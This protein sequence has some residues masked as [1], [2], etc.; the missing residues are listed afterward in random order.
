MIGRN[1]FR[2][3]AV[4]MLLCGAA[5]VSAQPYVKFV[6][7]FE[8]SEGY[9]AGDEVLWQPPSWSGSTTGILCDANAQG[10]CLAS[11]VDPFNNPWDNSQVVSDVSATDAQSYNIYFRWLDPAN[12]NG[13]AAARVV[14]VG[15][16]NLPSPSVQLNGKIRFKMAV[17]GWVWD[18][19]GQF[20]TQVT[21]GSSILM[22]LALRETG[23]DVAQ[24]ETDTGGG[25]L[26]FVYLPTIDVSPTV[27]TNGIADWPPGGKRYAATP[28]WPPLSNEWYNVEFDLDNLGAIIGFA[29]NGDGIN[30]AGDGVLDATAVGDGVNRGVLDSVIFTNDQADTVADSFFIYIDDVEFESDVPDP[31]SP[32]TIQLPVYEGA[33]TVDVQ[34]TPGASQAQLFV[35]GN[36]AGT[37][38]PDG[39]GLATITVQAPYTPLQAGDVLT[40]KQ[41][42]DTVTSDFSNP[43]IVFAVGVVVADNFDAYDTRADLLTYWS[44]SITNTTPPD[45]RL[46]LT[47]G[48]AASCQNL[49]RENNPS[50][51]N[52]ARLYRGLGG[53]NGS[54]ASPLWMTWYMKHDINHGNART[55]V[56]LARF[57]D[58]QWS[59]ATPA[60]GTTGIALTNEIAGDFLTQ[61]TIQLRTSDPQIIGTNGAGT[62][63]FVEA[64][65]YYYALTG[66]DR[67]P[68]VWH[69]MQVEV[70][71]NV[72]NYY[73]DDVNVNPAEWPGGVPRPNTSPFDFAI[74]GMGYSNNGPT[75]FYDNFSVTEGSTALPFPEPNPV[76][77]PTVSDPLYPDD[78]AVTLVD[79]DSNAAEVAVYV[80]G[81]QQDTQAGPFLTNTATLTVPALNDGDEVTGTQTWNVAKA[82]MESCYSAPVIAAVP[83]VTLESPLVPGQ[84]SV[85][86]SNL[87]E[88]LASKV[89]VYSDLG[90]GSTMFLGEVLNPATDPISV[91]VTSLIYGETI[92]A[93][94]TIGGTESPNSA[95]VVVGV[96]APS[97]PG[98]AAPGDLLVTVTGVH[99]L[100]GTVTILVDGSTN[101]TLDVSTNGDDTVQVPLNSS[102]FVGDNVTATQTIGGYTSA[103]SNTIIVD[104]PMCLIVFRDEYETDTSSSYNVNI[105][106]LGLADDAAATFGW[107]YGTNGGIPPAPHSDT[108]M[109]LRLEANNF[110]LSGN[111]ASVTV[112]PIGYSF[113]ASN[114]YRIVFNMWINANG[115][116]PSGGTGSTEFF[117]C[118]VGYDGTTPN[119]DTSPATG[120]GG[121]FG[122]SG[123]SGSSYDV[124]AYKDAEHQYP[125]S[126]Q[127]AA[128]T[129]S[130]VGDN[131]NNN[132]Y[133][134][135]LFDTPAPPEA[136]TLLY[137]N[138]TGSLL[139]GSA[140]FAWHAVDVTV[141]GSKA[142]WSIND[143]PIV[144]LD[145]T[146]GNPFSGLDGGVNL[147][148]YDLFSS[149]SDNPAMSFGLA[150]NFKVLVPHTPGTNGDYDGDADVD[151]VDHDY[152]VDCLAGPGAMPMPSTGTTCRNICLDV[153]DQDA[154]GDVD[155]ADYAKFQTQI[156]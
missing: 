20:F 54:D 83:S 5:S 125:E 121:W 124:R 127:Y 24:G 61:Y 91:P 142:R 156:P 36:A 27:G 135:D 14:T 23:N 25:D 52:A 152:L 137:A 77:A 108:T 99:P 9:N 40:A 81:V 48:G 71:D 101:G 74:F 139:T 98:P 1:V 85:E 69:K 84:T 153:F 8:T 44:D 94:Q 42:K 141:Y 87:E 155:L 45:A 18:E 21:S 103:E 16:D 6:T 143:T 150:D 4:S 60:E 130:G 38:I 122:I 49:L 33:T 41:T 110:D 115:P 43:V 59:T 22:C 93:T 149:V 109:G 7:G 154:D 53:V 39:S 89:S 119:L 96:P 72:Y 47:T 140:G 102:L 145:A 132:Q 73:I 28:N 104:L 123:E 58:G 95:G 35:N 116:F 86:V 120:S 29:N 129:V 147:G 30:T 92:V 133:Y 114:G 31:V 90:G 50:G 117:A 55:R 112:S 151:L 37:G 75:F 3:V 107:D 79:I 56:Q 97:L 57:A 62:N 65:G 100:A 128:G 64:S 17:T 111:A 106:D 131:T 66:V 82:L 26:E 78:T 51:S 134:Y 105:R 80:N 46:Q 12:S 10:V 138:Q 136:Q 146:I 88:G 126:G 70:Q 2:L 67:V 15:A 76:P 13:L 148:Y 63:G 68:G 32:P 118:G 11:A 144:T 113:I 34:C 19:D